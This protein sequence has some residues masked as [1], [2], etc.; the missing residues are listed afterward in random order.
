MWKISCKVKNT[1]VLIKVAEKQLQF[2]RNIAW[3][4]M[5]YT[6]TVYVLRRSSGTSATLILEGK[7]SDFRVLGIHEEVDGIKE[8][9]NLTDYSTV[10]R[11]SLRTGKLE[12]FGTSTSYSEDNVEQ[13][14][15]EHY[16]C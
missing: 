5:A 8:W 2:Y 11:N 6:Y 13:N 1:E 16:S 12:S 4:K 14:R 9:T 3:Q 15:T 7:T 10:K